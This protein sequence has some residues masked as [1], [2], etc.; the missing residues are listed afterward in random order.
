MKIWSG[1]RE[2]GY[3]KK[4]GEISFARDDKNYNH[5]L[6][7]L[8]YKEYKSFKTEQIRLRIV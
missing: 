3:D 8:K 1:I 5:K 4:R 2:C 6:E 7:I